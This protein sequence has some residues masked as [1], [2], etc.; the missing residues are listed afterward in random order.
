MAMTG[1]ERGMVYSM[2]IW[3]KFIFMTNLEYFIVF[4]CLGAKIIRRQLLPN[5]SKATEVLISCS[6]TRTLLFSFSLYYY[7]GFVSGENSKEN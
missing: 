3:M 1:L 7:V 6:Y 4:L 5:T 2:K